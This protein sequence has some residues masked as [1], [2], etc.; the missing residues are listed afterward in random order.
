MEDEPS[1]SDWFRWRRGELGLL[2]KAIAKSTSCTASEVSFW[3]SGKRRPNQGQAELLAECLK[4]TSNQKDQFVNWVLGLPGADFTVLPHPEPGSALGRKLLLSAS[5]GASAPIPFSLLERLSG[6]DTTQPIT[7]L[8]VDEALRELR[9]KKLVEKVKVEITNQG[10]PVELWQLD[11]FWVPFVL[12]SVRDVAQQAQYLAILEEALVN[13]AEHI[14]QTKD[15]LAVQPYLMPHLQHVIA[16]N[17][18]RIDFQM[19]RL[20]KMHGLLLY[21]QG[22]L[23]GGLKQLMRARDMVEQHP[24][25]FDDAAR[26]FVISSIYKDVGIVLY[27][28]GAL[29]GDDQDVLRIIDYEGAEHHFEVALKSIKSAGGDKTRDAA[30][31]CRR[32]ALVRWAMGKY[33]KAALYFRAA[34]DIHEQASQEDSP[35]RKELDTIIRELAPPD[36]N[37]WIELEKLYKQMVLLWVLDSDGAETCQDEALKILREN[38]TTPDKVVWKHVQGVLRRLSQDWLKWRST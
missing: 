15:A 20:C 9:Y 29:R 33:D 25:I 28:I 8:K 21:R 23:P 24:H 11:R 31:I 16:K 35:I 34:L 13:E 1:W 38:G 7:R 2:Q 14:I 4:L 30:D 3:E 37:P 12:G 32:L 19:F 10:I 36:E 22:D 18:S 26:P 27:T 17:N 5:Y 6:L